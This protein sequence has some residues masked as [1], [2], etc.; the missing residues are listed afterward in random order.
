M[1]RN[2]NILLVTM[3]MG[4]MV[5]FGITNSPVYA[6]APTS[7]LGTIPT[8]SLTIGEASDSEGSAYNA[9]TIT[10]KFT[11]L[12]NWFSWGVA[13]VAVV[14]GLYAG[15]LFITARGEAAQLKTARGTLLWAVIGI[16]VAV[17]AF[18]IIAITKAIF[19]L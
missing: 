11:G 14:M 19:V 6:D 10:G 5:L 15:F 2:K 9:N 8:G 16:A 17:L 1:I 12:I 7:A 18:S 3:I 13:L 4:L